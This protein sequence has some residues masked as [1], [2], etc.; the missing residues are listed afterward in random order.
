[1]AP[2]WRRTHRQ[3]W[4]DGSGPGR[5]RRGHPAG[6]RAWRL[7]SERKAE[8]GRRCSTAV[9]NGSGMRTIGPTGTGPRGVGAEACAKCTP[10]SAK[11][12]PMNDPLGSGCGIEARTAPSRRHPNGLPRCRRVRTLPDGRREQC[13]RPASWQLGSPVCGVHGGGWPV[14][15]ARG[16]RQNPIAASLRSG[17]H[18][19][20][21]TLGLGWSGA[22]GADLY[23]AVL[24]E[25]VRRVVNRM[26]RASRAGYRRA[27]EELRGHER[28]RRGRPSW[29]TLQ[30][31]RAL[32]ARYV[33]SA[34]RRQDEH[35]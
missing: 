1:M 30:A 3:R 35:E 23:Q 20:D 21:A 11:V 31:R 2:H 7:V 29:E 15:V 16:E 13:R 9:W 4:P 8:R 24:G 22:L 32:G 28:P 26:D 12:R 25:F 33:F 18:A 19:S 10:F 14:R 27:L 6:Y 17:R 5:A 34:L